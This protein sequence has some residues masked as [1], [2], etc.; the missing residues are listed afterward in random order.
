M[1]RDN[2]ARRTIVE[3]LWATPGEEVYALI[4]A[5]RDPS[6]YPMVRACGV[7]HECLYAGAIPRELAEVAPYLVRLWRDHPFTEELLDEGWGK[8]WGV[9]ATASCDVETLRSHLR[10]FLRVKREDGSTMVFRYYDPRVLRLYLPTCTGAELETFFGPLSRFV[11]EDAAPSRVVAFERARG[12]WTTS[13]IELDGVSQLARVGSMSS[14]TK[15]VRNGPAASPP[16][17]A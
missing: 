7:R 3:T 13:K 1:A 16:E 10:R 9:F 5:A 14:V 17:N 11:L 6:I 2:S 12:T 8:S 15:A 4:D